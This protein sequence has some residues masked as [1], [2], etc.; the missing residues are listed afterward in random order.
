[1]KLNKTLGLNFRV[2]IVSALIV[3]S[4]PVAFAACG[5]GT[6]D[7]G[8]TCDDANVVGGDGCS[9]TCQSEVCGNG[10]VDPNEECDD[11]NVV[12]GDG[13]GATCLLTGIYGGELSA[14]IIRTCG[15]AEEETSEEEG[16]DA[17]PGKCISQL[18]QLKR[19]LKNLNFFGL[20][21]GEL[22]ALLADVS[23]KKRLCQKSKGNSDD[24]GKGQ[25]NDKGKG[26]D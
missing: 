11:G 21:D 17:P 18:S 15:C 13:C 6:V 4:A 5:D 7:T 22:S 14:A 1:M 8:E 25:G 20:V 12:A 10:T 2:F 23:A 19:T 16:G 24:G 26:N 3:A 9:A